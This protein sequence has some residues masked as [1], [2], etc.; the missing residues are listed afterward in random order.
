MN[1][2]KIDRDRCTGCQ[3]CYDACFVDVFRWDK[4]NDQPLVA[5]PEDCVECNLC[6]LNCPE[7]C[8]EIVPDYDMYWPQVV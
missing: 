6:Q 1:A 8:I 7:E 5:Y 2:I 4:E 3:T